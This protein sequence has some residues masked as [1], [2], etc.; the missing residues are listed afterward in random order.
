M[1]GEAVEGVCD[2]LGA[3]VGGVG[4]GV[5][6]GVIPGIGMTPFGLFGSI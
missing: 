6:G 1:F 5:V 2:A 3:S 4:L